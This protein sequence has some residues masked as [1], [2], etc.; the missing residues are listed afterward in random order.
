MPLWQYICGYI[1]VIA[2]CGSIMLMLFSSFKMVLDNAIKQARQEAEHR[3]RILAERRY[4]QM[5]ANTQIRVRQ[6]LRIVND[7]DMGW[8]QEGEEVQI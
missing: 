6:Q 8:G 4:Q 3:A 1:T 7:S 5:L 2:A